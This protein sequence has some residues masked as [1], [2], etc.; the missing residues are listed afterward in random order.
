MGKKKTEEDKLIEFIG[1]TI[2]TESTLLACCLT[3]MRAGNVAKDS[4]DSEALIKVAKAW[5]DLAK[6]LGEPE[7]DRPNPIGFTSVLETFD[8]PGD[9]SD[10]GEGGPEVRKKFR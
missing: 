7:D 2:S 8:E 6:Y 3:L 4:E 9:E 5:Y 10:A 1:E